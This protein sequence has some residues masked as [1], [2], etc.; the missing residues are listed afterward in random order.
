MAPLLAHSPRRAL[1]CRSCF[2]SVQFNNKLGDFMQVESDVVIMLSSS[3]IGGSRLGVKNH[4][5]IYTFSV[6]FVMS[7]TSVDF[8]R[9]D[10][11]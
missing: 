11:A 8:A 2:R 10:A 3:W 5:H 4:L 6:I 7:L 1:S 9:L